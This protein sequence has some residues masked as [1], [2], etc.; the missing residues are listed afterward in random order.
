MSGNDHHVQIV[1]L[2]EFRGFRV[3]NFLG[4]AGKV[5]DRFARASSYLVERQNQ[6]LVAELPRACDSLLENAVEMSLRTR[7]ITRCPEGAIE[8]RVT[9]ERFVAAAEARIASRVQI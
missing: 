3:G 6:P 8:I 5:G 7:G 1:N 9:D 2:F 4:A